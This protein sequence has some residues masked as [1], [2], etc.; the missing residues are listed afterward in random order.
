[1]RNPVITLPAFRRHL[2]VILFAS[3]S[4]ALFSQVF[5]NPHII[6]D[7]V[8][9]PD[10]EHAYS[11]GF[12]SGNSWNWTVSSGGVITQNSGNLVSVQW[13]GPKNTS[14]YL[15]VSE[16]NPDGFSSEDTLNV[17]IKNTTLTCE[18]LVQVSL[19]QS[20]VALLTPQI[21]LEG[22]YN[23][24]E[25]FIVAIKSPT[26]EYI[27][28]VLNCSHVGKT[29]EVRV[30]DTCTGNACW[31][32]V[33]VKEKLPPVF[34][35][36]QGPIEIPCNTD[37]DNYPPPTVTDNCTADPLLNLAGYQIDN[38]DI[39]TGVW[40]TKIWFASDDYGNESSCVQVLHI[41][42]NAGVFFPPNREWKCSDYFAHP[43]VTD[44][45][46][47]T[48]VLATT[49]SGIP[50][51]TGGPFCQYSYNYSDDTLA[52][53][54]NAFKIIRTWSVLNW[55]TGEIILEDAN[56]NSNQQ[57]IQVT[58]YVA[59]TM[60]VPAITLNASVP[61]NYPFHCKSLD[62][63]PPP[64]VT[65]DC[66]NYTVRIFTSLGEAVYVNG[67]DGTQGGFVPE[68]GLPIG[69]HEVIYKAID[70]CGNVVEKTVTI[71][72]TDT[73]VP[74]AICDK[75]TDVNLTVY[76][77]AE[78]FASTF[79]DGSHDN[80]CIDRFE[81]KRMGQ[82]NSAF[83]SSLV[84]DCN[85][86]QVQVVLRVYDCFDNYNECMVTALVK[87]KIAP[88]CIAP[89]AQVISCTEVPATVTLQWLA[90]FGQP[91]YFDNCTATLTELP[92]SENINSCGEGYISRL[93]TV[94]DQAG[95]I[96]GTCEQYIHVKPKSDWKI[97]FPTNYYG[98]CTDT[99]VTGE[100]Q[101]INSGCD[102]WAVSHKD[103]LFVLGNDTACYKLVRTW[104]IINWCTYDPYETPVKL[105][106]DPQGLLIDDTTYENF[107]QYEY[108]Q[109]IVVYD[110]TPPT[111]SYPFSNEFCST[112]F[113]CAK[114]S[115]YLPLQ[116]NG[117][118]SN[119]FEIVYHLDL[120][121]DFS[122]EYHGTGY[123]DG[124]LPL[125]DHRIVYVVRD[126]C[127]NES[128][129]TVSFSV[130]D[131]KKP[132]ASC[133]NGLVVELMQTGMVPV[134]ASAF[135]DGSYDNC[136]GDLHFSFSSN[137][138]DSCRIFTC[139]DI[140]DQHLIQLWVTDAQGNQDYCETNIIIQDNFF[141]CDT[142]I[143][144]EGQVTTEASKAVEGVEVQINS[145]NDHLNMMTDGEGQYSFNGLVAGEDYT[146]TPLKDDQYLNGVTTFDLVLI[147]RHIL[148]IQLLDSPFKLIA[149]DA[150]SSKNIT[151]FDLVEI[152]KLILNI[153]DKFP[154]NTSWRFVDK[155]YAFPNPA[156]PWQE[157]FPEIINI[158]NLASP[159]SA[160]DFVAIKIGD[161]NGSAVPNNNL[162]DAPGNRDAG[163]LLFE[164]EKEDWQSGET[165]RVSFLS[166]D[167]LDVYGFQFTIDFDQSKLDFLG[168]VPTALTN[169]DNFGTT[170]TEEGAVTVSWFETTPVTLDNGEPVI[171]L[172][173]L[174][175]SACHADRSFGISSRYTHA[176]AYIGEDMA[177]LGVGL[178]FTTVSAVGETAAG[179]F[180]LYQNVP[181]PFN[182]QTA[183]GFR[184][185]EA[186]QATLTIVDALG[187][188][189]K[190]IEGR[191][192]AGYSELLLNRSEL[193]A[194]GILFYR[195]DT[196]AS[197]ATRAMTLIRK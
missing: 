131:C 148:G 96:S 181:N 106:N 30:L 101:I 74:A 98:S 46:P 38:S 135:N 84:F 164:M 167:F 117:E 25:G 124:E 80:C 90:G 55:C 67:V 1:M 99:V 185:P 152:R 196:P 76:G 81:A 12:V 48:V 75:F 172:E 175:K 133:S 110:N 97:Q 123:F 87:D 95:N 118:C 126:G 22:N 155:N 100:P 44:P 141:S 132:I 160:G 83:K 176:E 21:L 171:T 10:A 153:N 15:I 93:W 137:L 3:W 142:G 57:Q 40:V 147:S 173:F 103:Q 112:D 33:R 39:C 26:G 14:Q 36:P 28:D 104:K 157:A 89:T 149:A 13:T 85:D 43:N 186:S 113:D 102:M 146:I 197:S 4:C 193:P 192:P 50:E 189:V 194:Q 119:L 122:Y 61:G 94:V 128:Q 127:S 7:T 190:V 145:Y 29:L 41:S 169:P 82:P 177:L 184:L 20:G 32:S 195:L 69:Q 27:G 154:N 16:T 24:Y 107:G 56:G 140:L 161:V 72:V 31:S 8:V 70:D 156:N 34:D 91:S 183:I 136:P 138:A 49:G 64:V 121:N 65:D 63:L 58:D 19:D 88:T 2:F 130:I 150:N 77:T 165:V 179:H 73:Q 47:V 52:L 158:N 51:G 111:L 180:E 78:V 159:A 178:G 163:Q 129:I 143:P 9:C 45:S 188:I 54:G 35:C 6:G 62:L 187:K 37:V 17:L 105:P 42:P 86:S 162:A 108:Q 11:T 18:D 170:L 182:N 5:P 166:K 92:W 23:T 134:C 59:P 125:G 114:G 151:T 116:I 174:A 191:Y 139:A 71:T 115:V 144:L 66:S 120:N 60:T 53:C 109:F 68:P 168:I 79:D